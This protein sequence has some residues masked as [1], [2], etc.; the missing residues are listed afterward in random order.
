MKLG[1]RITSYF[2][3][4]QYGLSYKTVTPFLS[5]IKD[6][7]GCGHLV[8]HKKDNCFSFKVNSL[9]NLS[10]IIIPHFVNHPLHSEKLKD[11]LIFK[12]IV[13]M[14]KHK[15]HLDLNNINLIKEKAYLMNTVANR[16]VFFHL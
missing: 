6:F 11:F 4:T 5:E 7:F 12:K 8:Y 13:C 9:K 3:L 1:V 15:K 2:V 10:E 16:L 14:M